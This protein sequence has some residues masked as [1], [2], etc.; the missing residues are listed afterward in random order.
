MHPSKGQN[1]PQGTAPAREALWEGRALWKGTVL[2][3]G[4]R[5]GGDRGRWIARDRQKR[6]SQE[7]KKEQGKQPRAGWGGPSGTAP[8]LIKKPFITESPPGA[9]GDPKRVNGGP[10][11]VNEG[12]LR[13]PMEALPKTPVTFP[14]EYSQATC[15]RTGAQS[16]Q[17][18]Q[19]FTVPANWAPRI[20][21]L[22]GSAKVSSRADSTPNLIPG[23]S[24]AHAQTDHPTFP[25]DLTMTS[26]FDSKRFMSKSPR[27]L[28][29]GCRY[30]SPPKC[31]TQRQRR[32]LALRSNL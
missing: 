24:S 29:G 30:C 26:R 14:E 4:H 25:S 15:A 13:A 5:C 1:P 21:P 20:I 3:L 7:T 27:A 18:L 2:P 22:H 10:I 32:Q 31:Q 19:S 8:N 12:P 6:S 23:P 16:V 9:S 28:T 17:A 11:R